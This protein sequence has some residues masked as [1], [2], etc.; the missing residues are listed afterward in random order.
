MAY[1]IPIGLALEGLIQDGKSLSFCQGPFSTPFIKEKKKK[2]CLSFMGATLALT[3]SIFLLGNIYLEKKKD[4][5]I[6]GFSLLL[7]KERTPIHTLEEIEKGISFLEIKEKKEQKNYPIALSV[8]NVSETLAF[9]SA[10]PT[11]SKDIEIT[12]FNYQLIKYPKA[13]TP[14]DPYLGKVTIE[15]KTEN[16][17]TASAFHDKFCHNNPFINTKKEISWE[18]K[19]SSYFLSFFLTPGKE[20]SL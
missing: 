3:C 9:L 17:K 15:I 13:L 4:R 14:K 1:A 10:H 2:M 12:K 7:P 5:L 11:L 19:S 6:K 16:P 20:T 8:A 18:E